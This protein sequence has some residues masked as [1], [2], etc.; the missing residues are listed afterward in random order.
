MLLPSFRYIRP[1]IHVL[2]S[3]HADGQFVG[4][5]MKR[6]GLGMAYG[7]STRG[8]VEAIRQMVQLSKTSHL[9]ITPDGPRG[10]RRQV[11]MGAIYLASQTGMPIVACG[12]GYSSAWRANS[13]DQFAFPRPFSTGCGVT[14]PPIFIPKEASKDELEGYRREVEAKFLA[15]TT[16]AERWAAT[17]HYDTYEYDVIASRYFKSRLRSTVESPE[18][19]FGVRQPGQ[20]ESVAAK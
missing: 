17:G 14:T 6:L 11:K 9:V 19:G 8:G 2:V 20:L 4:G 15:A 7:S 18:A 1:D 16:I 10:P 3:K 13:W 12:C 5:V